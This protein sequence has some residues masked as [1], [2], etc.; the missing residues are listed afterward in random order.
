MATTSISHLI[1]ECADRPGDDPIFALNA[2]A[3]ERQ[4]AKEDVLNSTLGALMLDDGRLAVMPS[5]F[6]AM[7]QISP[8]EGAR[9]AEQ[10]RTYP[11]P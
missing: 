1:P 10:A 5:V 2:E 9:Q 3:V 8:E 11:T 4:L 6:E 7:R